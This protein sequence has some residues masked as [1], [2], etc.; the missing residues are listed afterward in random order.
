MGTGRKCETTMICFY[1]LW[2]L[3]PSTQML[4]H[5]IPL[6]YCTLFGLKQFLYIEL[7]FAFIMQMC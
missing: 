2:G 3:F 7:N 1:C 4:Q 6:E 5:V